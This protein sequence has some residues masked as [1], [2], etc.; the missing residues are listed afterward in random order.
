[1]MEDAAAAAALPEPTPAANGRHD[2]IRQELDQFKVELGMRL[3]SRCDQIKRDLVQAGEA[4]VDS[5]KVE[6]T[7]I[8]LD[9]DR[10]RTDCGQLQ[11]ELVSHQ[12]GLEAQIGQWQGRLQRLLMEFEGELRQKFAGVDAD[13]LHQHQELEG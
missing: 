6:V 13:L 3:D 10:L 4:V 8:S 5:V 12:G 11:S 1:M 9:V 2:N 7:R